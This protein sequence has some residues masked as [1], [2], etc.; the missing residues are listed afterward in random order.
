VHAAFKRF[1]PAS[2]APFLVAWVLSYLVVSTGFQTFGVAS[3]AEVTSQSPFAKFVHST[4]SYSLRFSFSKLSD[5]KGDKHDDVDTFGLIPSS[6]PP[7]FNDL[8]SANATSALLF[9][10]TKKWVRPSPRSPPSAL[11]DTNPHR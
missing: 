4:Q 9:T 5:G 10:H 1:Y 7:V 6:F 8:L 3:N 11:S 2:F